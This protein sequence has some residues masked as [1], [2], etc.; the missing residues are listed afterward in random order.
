MKK[1]ITIYFLLAL[2]SFGLQS[3]LFQED[4]Y[5]DD[6]SANRATADV[7]RY[8][9]LLE[10]APN[11]WRMEYYI[12]E[13]YSLG[14]ITLLCKFDGQRVKMASQG[15][16]GSET[17]SSLYKVVSEEATML[18]FDTY[19][20]YIHSFG[21]PQG[22]NPNPN[23]NLEGDYEFIITDSS[24]DQIVMR[25]KKYGNTIVMHALPEDLNWETYIN[26]V[27]ETE[28]SAFFNRYQ[29]LVDGNSLGMMQQS[30]YT[31]VIGY[32][33][34]GNVVQMQAP[35]YFT[36]DGLR[37]RESIAL[38]GVNVQNF[39][40]DNA[41]ETFTCTDAGA[42]NVSLKGVYPE[43]YIKYEDYLGNYIL[44]CSRYQSG[45]YQDVELPIS[46]VED[47][48]NKSFKLKGLIGDLTLNYDRADGTMAFH[49]QQVGLVS[50]YYLGCTTSNAAWG[51]FYPT[52]VSYQMGIMFGLVAEVQESP[53]E[54]TFVDDGVFEQ[55]SGN[56][57]ADNLIFDRYSAPDYSAGSFVQGVACIYEE[58]VFKKVE[59]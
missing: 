54:F 1:N 37:F 29:L 19:N 57:A 58:M 25:G 27:N 38:A 16:D 31:F 32:N 2:V 21:R 34:G 12:G 55:L 51:S 36:T 53:F 17:I 8:N 42:T 10:S 41:T 3:C 26:S 45:K 30:N 4:D 44:S 35:F 48:A 50:G 52:Y 22:V 33:D 46:I 7:K 18:T 6:S 5:F 59:E 43:G 23:G 14:G 40:W 49:T 28:E 24:A 39:V 13:D 15:Y 9:E 20:E 47:V 11:G 56:G